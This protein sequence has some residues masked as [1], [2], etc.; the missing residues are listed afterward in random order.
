MQLS[1]KVG[2]YTNKSNLQIVIGAVSPSSTNKSVFLPQENYQLLL[3]KSAPVA[4][5]NYSG[6]IV[7]K[8]SGG[9]KISGYSNYDRTL[10][11]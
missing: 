10:S 4:T 9:Y 1:Y 7:E 3:Y 2:G 6:V 5:T 11:C 8:S